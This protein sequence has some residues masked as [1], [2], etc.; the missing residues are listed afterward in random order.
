M[1]VDGDGEGLARLHSASCKPETAHYAHRVLMTALWPTKSTYLL[2]ASKEAPSHVSNHAS[3]SFLLRA[4][5]MIVTV[6]QVIVS[7]R[8]RE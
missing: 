8:H 7:T 2:L 3:V 6:R 4:L 1:Q 5:A